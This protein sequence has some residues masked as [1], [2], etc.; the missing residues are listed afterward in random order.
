MTVHSDF[1][2]HWSFNSDQTVAHSIVAGPDSPR[3]CMDQASVSRTE[4]DIF[5]SG[6]DMA[7]GVGGSGVG[8]IVGGTG[9]G[10]ADGTK[11]V[12]VGRSGVGVTDGCSGVDD[13]PGASEPLVAARG[14]HPTRNVTIT[15]P[16]ATCHAF[17]LFIIFVP[18]PHLGEPAR[19]PSFR[20]MRH[21][22]PGHYLTC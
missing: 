6:R 11:S 5:L 4:Q 2:A 12:A 22:A 18:F 14:P 15:K 8:V 3:I 9:V 1:L 10:V 7:V 20:D 13:A 21:P 19:Y 16:I 17:R